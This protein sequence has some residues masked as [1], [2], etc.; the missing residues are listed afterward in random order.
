MREPLEKMEFTGTD[1]L[2]WAGFQHLTPGDDGYGN[3][4]TLSLWQPWA[5]MIAVG[6]KR[7]ET[8]SWETSYRGL[9]AIHAAKRPIPKREREFWGRMMNSPR[10]SGFDLDIEH[11]P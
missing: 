11:L 3:F 8:R 4:R 5:S 6:L 9:L 1:A 2:E 10:F 7:H